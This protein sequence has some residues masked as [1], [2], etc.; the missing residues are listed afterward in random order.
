MKQ[1]QI[2]AVWDY[3]WEHPKEGI[4][5]LQ[6]IEKFGATRLSGIIYT[7]KRQ[8]LVDIGSEWVTVKTRY[9]KAHVKRYFI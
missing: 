5:S 7:L 2:E 6:A 3:M 9:G 1:T 8:Y 4:T